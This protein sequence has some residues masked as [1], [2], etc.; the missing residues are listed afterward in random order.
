MYIRTYVFIYNYTCI[1]YNFK[2][3]DSTHIYTYIL[4]FLYTQIY[5]GFVIQGEN[6]LSNFKGID[7]TLT[8]WIFL[9]KKSTTRYSFI[10]GKIIYM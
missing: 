4:I 6:L 3:I 8:L 10:T 2:G 9:K 1:I 7:F 5:A